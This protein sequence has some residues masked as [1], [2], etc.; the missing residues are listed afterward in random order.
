MIKLITILCFVCIASANAQTAKQE[1]TIHQNWQFRQLGKSE[2][3]PARV[4]GC[5][6]TDLMFN[7][8]IPDPYFRDNEKLV[9]WVE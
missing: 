4:P 5:I 7:K 9:Q 1:Q 6:H 3:Y 8:L 2:Y